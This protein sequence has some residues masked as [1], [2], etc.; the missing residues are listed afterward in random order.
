MVTR[1]RTNSLKPK[2]FST[3]IIPSSP[4]EPRT[5]KQSKSHKCWQD[6]M[7]SEY[8]ALMGNNTWSLVLCPPNVNLVGC[9]W[10]YKIKHKSDRSIECYKAKLVAQGYNQEEVDY[11]ETFCPVIKPTTIR[12]VLSITISNNWCIHQL[13]IYNSFLNGELHETVYVRQP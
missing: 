7:Q 3:S 2:A 11:F 9:K 1:A 13:D 4:T 12:L 8:D 5:Y 10:I 6:A